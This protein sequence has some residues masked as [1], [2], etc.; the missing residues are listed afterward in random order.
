MNHFE[1]N[2]SMADRVTLEIWASEVAQKN[3]DHLEQLESYPIITRERS[4]EDI[5][6]FKSHPLKRRFPK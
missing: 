6:F 1:F 4:E 3:A 5:L 2:P